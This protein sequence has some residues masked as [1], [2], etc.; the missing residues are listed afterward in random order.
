[1]FNNLK[2]ELKFF[3]YIFTKYPTR[4]N[5]EHVRS[6]IIKINK[7]LDS[8]KS[9]IELIDEQFY[10]IIQDIIKK[11]NENK[12]ILL[13]QLNN[14]PKDILELLINNSKNNILELPGTKI[15]I[16]FSSESRILIEKQIESHFEFLD[17]LLNRIDDES[18]L[19]IYKIKELIELKNL[20]KQKEIDE[21]FNNMAKKLTDKINNEF[22]TCFNSFNKKLE[23]H[24]LLNDD[25][26]KM[27]SDCLKKS[28]KFHEILKQFDPNKASI[29]NQLEKNIINQSNIL[30]N[31]I[32]EKEFEKNLEQI[33]QN[34]DN[35]SKI[36]DLYTNNEDK[37]NLSRINENYVQTKNYL[38][39]KIQE[40]HKII[41]DTVNAC[42]QSQ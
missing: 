28:D 4:L 29:K 16:S 25:D 10:L 23:D 21:R 42:G 12:L 20:I 41:N 39:E 26:L 32:K 14:D 8:N 17:N 36:M 22:E 31:N 24:Y 34:F 19:I 33:K 11:T 1:M 35:L 3:D 6:Q 9:K 2:N 5:S 18:E 13:N 27:Y 30:A 37:A 15:S 7:E 38:L 40:K